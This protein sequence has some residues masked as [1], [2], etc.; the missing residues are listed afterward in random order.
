MDSL[1]G[2]LFWDNWQ[3]SAAGP[4]VGWLGGN[5]L[6]NFKLTI[7]YPNRVTYWQKQVESDIHD[8]DQVG[9]TLVRRSDR[10]FIGG[11]VRK[12]NHGSGDT[13]TV[14]GVEIGDELLA[15]DGVNVPDAAK[16]TILSHCTVSRASGG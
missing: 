11:I 5:V 13:P 2:D 15:V 3:K 14:E 4:V 8:L 10:Y 1:L 7:D 6:K 16:D 12:S 9:I